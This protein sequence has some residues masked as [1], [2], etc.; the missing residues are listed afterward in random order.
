MDFFLQ[1][2]KKLQPKTTTISHCFKSLSKMCRIVFLVVFSCKYLKKMHISKNSKVNLNSKHFKLY[3]KQCKERKSPDQI[4]TYVV[5]TI[6]KNKLHRK[7][8]IGIG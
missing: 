6:S 4:R 8:P 1:W 3:L 5:T 2:S 7:D